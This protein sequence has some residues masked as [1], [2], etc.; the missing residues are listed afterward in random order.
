[1]S[2]ANLTPAAVLVFALSSAA[3]LQG[4]T[5]SA[6]AEAPSCAVVIDKVAGMDP[7]RKFEEPDRKLFGTM[8]EVMSGATRA[9]VLKA[10]G[11]GDFDKCLEAAPEKAKIRAAALGS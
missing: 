1:M 4:C 8:C 3:V 6:V 2:S 7:K 11:K 10:T 9:C 5:K